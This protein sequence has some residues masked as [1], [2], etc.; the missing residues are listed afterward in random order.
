MTEF[1]SDQNNQIVEIMSYNIF[2]ELYYLLCSNIYNVHN[3]SFSLISFEIII[4]FKLFYNSLTM[5]LI[6]MVSKS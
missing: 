1:N 6:E 5:L 3:L 2:Y 4:Y